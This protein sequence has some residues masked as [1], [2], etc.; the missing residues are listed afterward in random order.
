MLPKTLVLLYH[1]A[2][3]LHPHPAE[4]ITSEPSLFKQTCNDDL[5]G[6]VQDFWVSPEDQLDVFGKYYG[7]PSL[8]W[9]DTVHDLIA[10]NVTGFKVSD[11]YADK[12]HPNGYNGHRCTLHALSH[13]TAVVCQP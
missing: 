1:L 6:P 13:D 12:G 9:R 2:A 3:V 10:H 11:L 8:S 4:A 7:L 5:D